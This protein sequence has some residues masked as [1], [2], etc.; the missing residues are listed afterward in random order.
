MPGQVGPELDQLETRLRPDGIDPGNA[1]G[2]P[3]IETGLHGMVVGREVAP[4]G[5]IIVAGQY[6]PQ[7]GRIVVFPHEGETVPAGFG[8]QAVHLIFVSVLS[9]DLEDPGQSEYA[10]IQER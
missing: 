6:L 1:L 8:E 9:Q 4:F 5:V 10:R 2:E 7:G 3:G